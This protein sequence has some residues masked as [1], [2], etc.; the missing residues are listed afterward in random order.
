M[1]NDSHEDPQVRRFAALALGKIGPASPNALTALIAALKSPN[2]DVRAAASA[3][4][5]TFG[6]SAEGA[7][8]PLIVALGD[9][10]PEVHSSV[11]QA[12][13]RIGQPAIPALMGALH[14]TEPLRRRY[15]ALALAQITPREPATARALLPLLRDPDDGIRTSTVSALGQFLTDNAL[16]ELLLPKLVACLADPSRDVRSAVSDL[17]LSVGKVEQA[18]MGRP[19]TRSW[20]SRFS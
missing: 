6:P 1:L 2:E 3:A 12:L 11:C 14:E 19:P 13:G 5:F 8:V 7:I 20:Q 4:L 18:Q 9:P 15:A 10:N 17:L 16:T